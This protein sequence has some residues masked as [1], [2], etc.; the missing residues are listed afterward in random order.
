MNCQEAEP[1]VSVLFDGEHVPAAIADHVAGCPTCRERLRAYSEIG[2]ELRLLASRTPDAAPVPENLLKEVRGNNWRQKFSLFRGSLLVPRFAAALV[3]GALLAMS[4]GL[5]VLRAQSQAHSLWFQFELYPP[6]ADA[7]ASQDWGHNVAQTGYDDQIGLYGVNNQVVGAHIAVL[8]IKEGRVQVA[9][10]ARR[11]GPE[12]PDR[13]KIKEKLDLKDHTFTYVPGQ[14]LEVPVEG[15]GMLTLR[16]EVADHQPKFAWGL[17]VEPR[18]DQ[19]V[20]TS[21]IVI[22]GNSLLADSGGGNA[23]AEGPDGAVRLYDRGMGL[24]TVALRQF[25]G[26]VQ[27]QANWGYL[28]FEING[29]SYKLFSASPISG[30]NQPHPVWVALDT[31]YSPAGMPNAFISAWSL[32]QPNP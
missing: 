2:A 24:L 11:Y 17:P 29:K 8:A 1:F 19:L 25:P 9:I 31:Q 5:M 15:G 14:A 23:I 28:G 30:G 20:L 13:F 10:R 6:W 27:S 16:G 32:G 21:P 12:D 26:A 22:S 7:Q 18:A 3:V 4:A